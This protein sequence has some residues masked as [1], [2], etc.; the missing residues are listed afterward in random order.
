MDA[1][2]LWCEHMGYYDITPNQMRGFS[3]CWLILVVLLLLVV[4]K[5][6]EK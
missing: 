5:K 6:P 1:F 4:L 3:L 2:I